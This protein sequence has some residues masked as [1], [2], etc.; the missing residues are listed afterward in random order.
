MTAITLTDATELFR[1]APHRYLDVGDGEVAYRRVG[2]GP[3]V[4]FV[5][6]FPVSGATF[7]GLLPHLTPHVTC[8]LL[9]L[10]G[11]GQSRFDR[12]AHV[13]FGGHIK[14]IRRVLDQLKLNDVAAVGHDSGGM[15]ARHALAGDPRLRSMALVDTEQPQGLSWKFR[16]FLWMTK[17]PRFERVLGWAAMQPRLR[18]NP[19][20]L[21]DCFV[22]VDLLDGEFEEFFLAPLRDN[23]NRQW[24]AGQLIKNFDVS[25]VTQ[26]AEVHRRIEVP[27]QLIWGEDDPFFPIAWTREMVETFPVARLHVVSRAKLFAHEEHPAE[28]AGAMLPTLLESRP[29][30]N[31]KSPNHLQATVPA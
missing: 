4:L 6:G 30:Q 7:R 21:G 22:D 10:V 12:N 31:G 19:A 13:S 1:S 14:S 26:L 8:H 9:D 24:A 29:G 25:Y 18:R 15:I 3:D 16:Q 28:V 5:H 11:A 23:P 2:S 17:L 20:L 27:V